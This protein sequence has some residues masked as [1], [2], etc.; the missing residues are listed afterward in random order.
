[1]RVCGTLGIVLLG[2]VLVVAGATNQT[3]WNSYKLA[4]NKNYGSDAEEQARK[5]IFQ[6]NLERVIEHNKLFEKGYVSYKKGL[7]SFSDMSDEEFSIQMYGTNASTIVVNSDNSIDGIGAPVTSFDESDVEIPD[8]IDWRTKGAVTPVEQQGTCGSCW[9]FASTGAL[10]AALFLKT[11]NLIELSKQNLLDCVRPEHDQCYPAS[12]RDAYNYIIKNGGIN[13]ESSYPYTGEKGKCNYKS[14][15]SVTTIR[16]Y[17]SL[18]KGDEGALT[19]AIGTIGP[20]TVAINDDLIKDYTGGVFYDPK[21]E[22]F[23]SNH[24]IL[25]VGYGTD[26]KHGDYYLIKNS[27]GTD[28]GEEGYIRFARN[29][30]NVCGIAS[31]PGYPIV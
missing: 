22:K 13:S 8:S 11:G 15:D 14:A 17:V 27:W 26:P 7:N 21:C 2:F 28:W 23:K 6:S 12:F 31:W 19:K 10:E 16:S 4:H 25:A 30:N 5:N 20:V 3:A 18:P 24:V 9:T 1:M 29:K